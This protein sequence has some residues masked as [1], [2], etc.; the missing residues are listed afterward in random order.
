MPE[1]IATILP[2]VFEE[3]YQSDSWLKWR[4]ARGP[5]QG[6]VQTDGLV[7]RWLDEK[8]NQLG[9]S[10]EL[11]PSESHWIEFVDREGNYS[12]HKA[13]LP[14]LVPVQ[15]PVGA[16]LLGVGD[17]MGINLQLARLDFG[18]RRLGD[19]QVH[20]TNAEASIVV[21]IIA[22]C[23]DNFNAFVDHVDDFRRWIAAQPPF[24][25]SG[26]GQNF[27][28]KGLFWPSAPGAGLFNTKPPRDPC[29][30]RF[31]GN[32]K[33]AREL[34]NSHIDENMPS[35]ILINSSHRGGAGGS[36]GYSAWA[37][38]GHGHHETWFAVALHELGHSFGL[39]D[40]YVDARFRSD[41][42]H[43][44]ESNVSDRALP[45]EVPWESIVTVDRSVGPSHSA[46]QQIGNSPSIVGTFVGARY[47]DSGRYRGCQECLMRTPIPPFCLVCQRIVRERLLETA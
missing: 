40:E 25:D 5:F 22:E 2:G 19:P 21:P 31:F 24:N 43:P 20:E 17:G 4:L 35:L 7:A 45:G 39:A 9:D 36:P 30:R 32:Q 15:M 27:G 8:F 47:L 44:L 10:F 46:A 33:I 38:T 12:W 37:S 11:P 42:P 26:I 28:F 1:Q 18:Q 29:D 16:K 3:I 6:S 14:I 34:L 13:D 41:E 23:F